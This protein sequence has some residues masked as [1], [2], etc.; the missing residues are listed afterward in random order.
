MPQEFYRVLSGFIMF[1]NY[2][3]VKTSVKTGVR[4]LDIFLYFVYT[5]DIGGGH[6]MARAESKIKN[7]KKANSEESKRTRRGNGEG[8]ITERSD[9]RW[10]AKIQ[11][12]VDERGK[13]IIKSFYGKER[14][15]VVAK[16]QQYQLSVLQGYDDLTKVNFRD[17][18]INWM[19]VIKKDSLKESSFDRLES[20]INTHVIPTIGHYALDKLTPEIIKSEVID[21]MVDNNMSYSTVK[22]A[23]NA[24]NAC[25]R[26][27]VNKGQ[28][29]RNP[30]ALV[31]LPSSTK[32]DKSEIEIFTKEE[33]DK[34]EEVVASKFSNGKY[35]YRT[36]YGFVLILYT[37]LRTAEALALQWGD[38]DFEKK[39]IHIKKNIALVRNR[40]KKNEDEANYVLKVQNS[41][42]TESGTRD[43]PLSEKALYALNELKKISPAG[44]KDFVLCTES[45]FPI[46][47]RNFRN[48]FDSILNQ[49]GIDSTGMH[50]LRHTFASML[51]AKGAE[52]KEVS[53]LLGH[54]SVQ[55]TYD[56][57]I[58]LI[59]EHK[60]KVISLLDD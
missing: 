41:T 19:H 17:Y 12:G 25:C 44:K 20:T 6:K 1:F 59:P 49:A 58:H 18:I 32:F 21:Y 37:G 28:L 10:V 55:I 9:G 46:R 26:Y 8:S 50:T 40:K 35:K 38:V 36:G 30:A 54:A 16:L 31:A 53:E 3:G 5:R 57:Y 56:T 51:F 27:A 7:T 24:V 29:I 47:P 60:A 13:Q 52:V 42:K 14:R 23:Y 33:V 34:I 11:I 45:G 43:I 2:S 39:I 22:K 15:E 4:N 48:T